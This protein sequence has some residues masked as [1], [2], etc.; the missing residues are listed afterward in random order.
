MKTLTIYPPRYDFAVNDP[1]WYPIFEWGND[2]GIV[3]RSHTSFSGN[4]SGE[5]AKCRPRLFIEIADMFPNMLG[6]GLLGQ[7]R[8]VSC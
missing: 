8:T 6:P 7:S 4:D 5:N 1:A 3:I 2:R